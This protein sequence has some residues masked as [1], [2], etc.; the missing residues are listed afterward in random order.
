MNVTP[1]KNGRTPATS[2]YETDPVACQ[3]IALY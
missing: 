2:L 3:T 1:E